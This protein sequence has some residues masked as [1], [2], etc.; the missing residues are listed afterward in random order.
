MALYAVNPR[1]IGSCS[2]MRCRAVHLSMGTPPRLARGN[3]PVVYLAQAKH[4]ESC[5]RMRRPGWQGKQFPLPPWFGGIA[6]EPRRRIGPAKHSPR[7]ASALVE[8]ALTLP[9]ARQMAGPLARKT[10]EKSRAET[11]ISKPLHRPRD[12]QMLS[13]FAPYSF[14]V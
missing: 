2:V 6:A 4:R 10:Q 8:L 12:P 13:T 14:R 1:T 3:A 5:E 11:R 7:A 9:W